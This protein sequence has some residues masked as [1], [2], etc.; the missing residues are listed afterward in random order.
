M[1]KADTTDIGI[2]MWPFIKKSG[3]HAVCFVHNNDLWDVVLIM[4]LHMFIIYLSS[5]MY[6][7]TSLK[8]NIVN[9]SSYEAIFFD[10]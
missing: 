6:L 1:C 3:A 5:I 4:H 7:T 10:L 2:V 8:N 9:V